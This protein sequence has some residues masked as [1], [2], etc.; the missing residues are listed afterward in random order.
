MDS[1]GIFHV[2]VRMFVLPSGTK[3]EAAYSDD[4]IHHTCTYIEEIS[5][6]RA[7]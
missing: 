5:L 3:N 4:H 6:T 1:K 7:A 2:A